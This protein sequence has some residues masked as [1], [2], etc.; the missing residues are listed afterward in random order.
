MNKKDYIP[1]KD[2][3]FRTWVDDFTSFVD[4]NA[5]RMGIPADELQRL[6][7][8]KADWDIKF[9]AATNPATRTEPAII[10]KQEARKTLE[11]Y[12]RWFVKARIQ[13]N[14]LVSDA[15]RKSLGVPVYKKKRTPGHKPASLVAG[16]IDF[17]V[18]QQHTLHFFGE[19]GSGHAR[20]ADAEGCEIWIKKGGN[21]PTENEMQYL[22][23]DSHSPY[24]VYFNSDEVGMIVYYRLRWVN[25]HGTGPWSSLISAVVPG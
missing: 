13:P 6:K 12:V 16:R 7:T 1:A 22:G 21:P 3:N 4:A 9:I 2:A 17:S 19:A 11:D 25:R 20:P 18:R 24:T 5:T 14:P 10:A 23:T 15:D 8:L